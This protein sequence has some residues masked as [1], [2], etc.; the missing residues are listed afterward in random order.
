MPTYPELTCHSLRTSKS[1]AS[2]PKTR[3]AMTRRAASCLPKRSFLTG[4]AGPCATRSC[5]ACHPSGLTHTKP[6][7]FTEFMEQRAPG[8]TVLDDKI[9][10]AGL[11]D[12][13]DGIATAGAPDF[14]ADPDAYDKREELRAMAIACEAVDPIRT[15]ACGTG[16]RDGGHPAQI[17]A[18]RRELMKIADVC[19]HVPAHG[20]RDFHEALQA[21]WFCH[22]AV[23]TELNGWDAFSPGH[24]D[25]HL[26]PF[27]RKGRRSAR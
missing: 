23:I 5:R 13:K 24:L 25:Q 9:Y 20:P 6:D 12:L 11:D 2:R 16:R 3:Y 18:R 10:R 7:M 17:R 21:Y 14:A 15:P 8:H 22:L 19:R 1:S 4:A 27:Y 26:R